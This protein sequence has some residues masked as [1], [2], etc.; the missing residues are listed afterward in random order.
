MRGRGVTQAV[1]G[2]YHGAQC[3]KEANGIVGA[4]NIVVDGARQTDAGEAHLS[5]THG[6]HIGTVTT[7][8]HQR[9]QAALSH[10]FNRDGANMFF[11]EFW[12]TRRPQ[13]GAAAV[14]HVGN[15]VAVELNHTIFIQAEVTV[16][17]SKNFQTFR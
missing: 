17:D 9:I 7:D 5:Q 8:N 11:A 2:L 12:K 10:I 4:F 14:D 6:A 16:I 13:E 1:N 15:A 3:G